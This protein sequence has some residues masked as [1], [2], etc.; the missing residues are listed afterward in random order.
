M[1][2]K[3]KLTYFNLRGRA[4]PT[5]MLLAY[6]GIEFEDCRVANEGWMSLKPKTPY[7]SLPVMEWNGEVMAQSVTIARFVAKE[8]G[9]A[10]R[11]NMECAQV[12]EIVDAVN[13][14]GVAG[15]QAMFSKDEER[16][17]KFMSETVPNGL[18]QLEKR[19]VSRG[20]Q[21]FVG[22][23][24]SWADLQ[25]YNLTSG[26]PDQSMLNKFPKIKNLMGR[27]AEIPNIKRWVEKRPVTSM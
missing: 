19:L 1:A 23:A 12:D 13:D 21:Y 7:G 18:A 6:G 22:N 17:K 8:V 16:I 24:F 20:G 4:E 9:L 26:F 3:V 2:P 10:G 15:A 11:N 27:V 5:R 14:I 25:L